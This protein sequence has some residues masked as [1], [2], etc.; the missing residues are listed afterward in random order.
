MT[1]RSKQTT[2]HQFRLQANRKDV[3][4]LKGHCVVIEVNMLLRGRTY[5]STPT[6]LVLLQGTHVKDD[7]VCWSF[8]PQFEQET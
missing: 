7:A 3:S 2:L 6:T 1:H 5:R 8:L 4:K